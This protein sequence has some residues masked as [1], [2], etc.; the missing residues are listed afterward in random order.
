MAKQEKDP[1]ARKPLSAVDFADHLLSI[2]R[3]LRAEEILRSALR[4][5]LAAPHVVRFEVRLCEGLQLAVA[6]GGSRRL[7]AR[8]PAAARRLPSGA[9]PLARA[10]AA[11]AP[12][13]VPA[14]DAEILA[15]P[16]GTTRV[17]LTRL[18]E[19]GRVR[20]LT[21]SFWEHPENP[22]VDQRLLAREAML[23][24]HLGLALAHAET[25]S[26]LGREESRPVRESI[27]KDEEIRALEERNLLAALEA[28][29]GKVAG[30][31]GAAELLGVNP[32]TLASRVRALGLARGAW[33]RPSPDR[34]RSV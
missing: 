26:A 10:L 30:P 31:G 20:G 14:E 9:Q 7:D 33:S 32:S 15:P 13:L 5:Q 2:V 25:F 11:D 1:P 16:A 4:A 27:L 28:S 12:L 23:S 34:G 21:L 8:R 6:A 18:A 3:P 22:E 29:G 17:A 19:G 24:G